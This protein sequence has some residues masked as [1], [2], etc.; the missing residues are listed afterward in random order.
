MQIQRVNRTTAE[1][2]Y[3]VIQ[4][5]E[6]SSITTGY[7]ARYVGGAAAEIVSTD[8][9]QAVMLDAESTWANFAGI[10]V[11]DIPSNGYGR[12]QV[13]GYNGSVGFSNVVTSITIGVTGVANS[14][15]QW[16]VKGLLTSALTPQALSTHAGKYVQVLT[17]VGLSTATNVSVI[18]GAGFIRG[19]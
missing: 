7:S 2:V 8:G 15:T 18:Y 6:A 9:V 13:W 14:F 4:N 10:A 16:A 17:T 19:F 12:V 5:V 3:N 11:Q 1:V